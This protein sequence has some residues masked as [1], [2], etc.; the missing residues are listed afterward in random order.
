MKYTRFPLLVCAAI[1]S[2]A[3]AQQLPHA[4]PSGYELPNGWRLKPLGR[5]I[6]TEDMVLNV[7]VA[8]DRRAVVALHAGFN[9]HGLVVVDA[10]SEEAAQRIPLKSAWLG[11]AWHPDGKK[12]Y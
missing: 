1:A 12:L 2:T 6:P 4:T 5:S 9:P 11:L 3:F 8:P 7:S 10:Q